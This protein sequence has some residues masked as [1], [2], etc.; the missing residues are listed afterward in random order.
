MNYLYTHMK[1]FHEVSYVPAC[2][3]KMFGH[4]FEMNLIFRTWFSR[5]SS[6]R[7]EVFMSSSGENLN[8]E[9]DLN[10]KLSTLIANESGAVYVTHETRFAQGSSAPTQKEELKYDSAVDAIKAHC[11]HRK[12]I[13][14][15]D[16]RTNFLINPRGIVEF[17]QKE[18]NGRTC[19][20][21]VVYYDKTM[22]PLHMWISKSDHTIRMLQEPAHPAQQFP[23]S[24]L[25]VLT[26][27]A[28]VT[29]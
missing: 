23:I 18:I 13:L 19:H 2:R 27:L 16:E 11:A 4:P 14:L 9:L 6:Y 15:L 28:Q 12:T 22:K 8:A 1:S 3:M 25:N 7:I 10:Q 5:P 17:P 24:V 21:L 26:S 29:S 20:N